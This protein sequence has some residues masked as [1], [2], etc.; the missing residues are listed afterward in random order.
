MCCIIISIILILATIFIYY[1]LTITYEEEVIKVL[2]EIDS[3]K[4]I[5]KFK[6]NVPDLYDYVYVVLITKKSNGN[7]IKQKYELRCGNYTIEE[8]Y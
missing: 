5:N 8:I 3:E 1:R 7:I 4:K 6:K 2:K